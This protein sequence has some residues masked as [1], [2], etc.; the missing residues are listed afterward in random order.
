MQNIRC[1]IVEDETPAQAVIEE[2]IGRLDYLTLA[3]KCFNPFEAI[4]FLRTNNVD[5]IFLDINMPGM[6]GT[7]FYKSLDN[8]PKVIFTTAYSEFAVEGFELEALDY[9]LKPISFE[10]FVKAVNKF[11]HS[12]TLISENSS[13]NNNY[14]D[15]FIFV[16]C[17]KR[18]IKIKLNEILFIESIKNYIRIKTINKDLKTYYKISDMANELPDDKFIQ[19]HRS[20]II[21]VDKIES[22][23]GT[24]VDVGDINVPVGK[25]YKDEF[26]NYMENLKNM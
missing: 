3:G 13:N 25:N 16:K 1:L 6:K 17:E 21:A 11:T 23:S 18:M 9:L 12:T 14:D 5:L 26:T 19:I 20:F 24:S 10:R 15:A 7:D 22:Y 2:F 8:K 4:N